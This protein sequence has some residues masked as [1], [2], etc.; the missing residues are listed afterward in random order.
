M[1]H[2]CVKNWTLRFDGLVPL[3][4]C[5]TAQKKLAYLVAL[6]SVYLSPKLNMR[7]SAYCYQDI[8]DFLKT[9]IFWKML[10]WPW[11][12]QKWTNV[13]NGHNRFWH[14]SKAVLCP[15]LT[16]KFQKEVS[17][18]ADHKLLCT[19]AI[20]GLSVNLNHQKIASMPMLL[21]ILITYLNCKTRR[22]WIIY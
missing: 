11:S 20:G 4:K 14:M 16:K 21:C 12:R 15:N 18:M 10:K 5:V 22:F 6:S 3:H 1:S 9:P 13:Q 8:F 7:D 19:T 2:E 17:Q